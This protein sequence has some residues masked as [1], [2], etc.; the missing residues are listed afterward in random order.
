MPHAG[1]FSDTYLI[2]RF[3]IKLPTNPQGIVGGFVAL[4]SEFFESVLD[5]LVGITTADESNLE[6]TFVF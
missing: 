4:K 3:L 6:F 1:S 2:R 5:F